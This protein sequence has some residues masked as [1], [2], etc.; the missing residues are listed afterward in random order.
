MHY[1]AGENW[2]TFNNN[3]FTPVFS[4]AFDSWVWPSEELKNAAISLCGGDMSCLFDIYV[5][6]DIAVG[7]ASKSTVEA[8]AALTSTLSESIYYLFHTMHRVS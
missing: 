3:T 4:D 6:G 1:E 7:E 8:D 2:F 5:T